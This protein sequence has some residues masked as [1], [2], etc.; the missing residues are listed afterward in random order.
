MQVI[1]LFVTL[2]GGALVAY[3]DISSRWI[4][5]FSII[6][7]GI[8]TLFYG[9]RNVLLLPSLLVNLGFLVILYVVLRL[10]ILVRKGLNEKFINRYMGMGDIWIMLVLCTGYSLYNYVV[11]IL[12]SCISALLFWAMRN[13]LFNKQMVRIPLAGFIAVTH[14]IL[15]FICTIG[16]YDPLGEPVFKLLT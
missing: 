14:C 5:L 10:Y 6:L 9:I 1:A 4:H 11:V 16:V 7:L 12:L 3:Q 15:F 8:G 13:Y 2:T